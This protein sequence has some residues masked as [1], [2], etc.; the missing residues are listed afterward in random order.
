MVARRA[1]VK[2]IMLGFFFSFATIHADKIPD[3][4]MPAKRQVVGTGVTSNTPTSTPDTTPSTPPTTSDPPTTS[5]PPTTD[6]NTTTDDGGDGTTQQTT[7]DTPT[8]TSVPTTV[9]ITT[10]NSDGETVTSRISTNTVVSATKTKDTDGVSTG[11]NSKGDSVV[12]VGSKTINPSTLSHKTTVRKPLVT[13]KTRQSTY[14][15]FWTSDGQVYSS[16]VTTE[17][18]F[19]STTG[20]ATAT[21]EPGLANGGGNGSN[22]STNTKKII[23]GV[24]GGIGG[25]ILI[26]GLAFVAW[27]LWGK[28]K[29]ANEGQ[30]EWY[31]GS[32]SDSIAN[33]KR[34]S[35][36]VLSASAYSDTT[37][38]NN[39]GLERYQNP[40]GAIN[41]SSNF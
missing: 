13:E 16:V 10:T 3:G 17:N 12:K 38:N 14:T 31:E 15:S 34:Q 36:G 4:V 40:N 18:V 39:A 21:I 8:S 33:Q 22:L 28:K 37:N 1:P 27:R 23:G 26:G 6:D 25:A 35:T 29:A 11:T 5:N 7:D 20:F 24:V 30:D 2:A 9:D 19:A 41:T 32:G